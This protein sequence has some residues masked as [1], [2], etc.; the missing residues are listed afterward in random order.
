MSAYELLLSESQERML[1]VAERGREDEVRRVFA[2]WELDA[3]QVGEVTADPDLTVRHR[4]EEV[5]RVPVEALA[6]APK[7]EK[8][9]AAPGWLKELV[10]FDPLTLSPPADYGEALAGR[11]GPP[12]IPSKEGAYRHYDHQVVVT[13]P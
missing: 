2:K 7:Y 9:Y 11:R 12:A 1:L 5:A 4:G 10:A 13:T 3:V 8:P 6:E